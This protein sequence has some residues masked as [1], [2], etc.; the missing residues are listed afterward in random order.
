MQS[1]ACGEYLVSALG[2]INIPYHTQW[3]ETGVK[4]TT[5]YFTVIEPKRCNVYVRSR[6]TSRHMAMFE[7]ENKYRMKCIETG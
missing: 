6:I 3:V 4:P 2:S 7:A 1:I 5:A